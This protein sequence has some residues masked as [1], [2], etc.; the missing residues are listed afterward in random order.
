MNNAAFKQFLAD[1]DLSVRRFSEFCRSVYIS[2]STIHRLA[3]PEA[4]GRHIQPRFL[5]RITPALI[6]NCQRWMEENGRPADEIN[7]VLKQVF[8]E[9]YEPMITERSKLDYDV[10]EFFAFDRDPFALEADPRGPEEAYTN[11]DLERIVRRVEDAVKFQGFVC[12]IGP[13]GAG[14]T[15][16]KNRITAKFKKHGKTRLL[17]PRFAEMHR[18]NA[19]GIV[20]YILEEFGQRGRIRLPL[21]QRQLELHLEQLS[22]SGHSVSLCIDECHR[23]NDVTLSALKNF[24]ELGTGGYEKYLGLVLFG[25][26][27]FKHRLEDS[28][29]REIAE[30]VEVIEMPSLAKHAA[31]YIGHRISLAG[32]NADKLFEPRAIAMIASQAGTP[33]AIGNLANKALIE[34]YKKGEPRVLARFLEKD[35][36]PQT[37]HLKKVANA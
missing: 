11:K 24:Y 19:G 18:L 32:G 3:N 27:S 29:F 10:L 30:R 31:D 23:L 28:R 7:R 6:Q 17:W 21:A 8:E 14:K 2:K 1:Y 37:R 26:P 22:Q 16:L 12:I 33:L 9:D 34:A 25:Q 20:H 15:S 36:E 4:A 35:T 5:Q 13:V